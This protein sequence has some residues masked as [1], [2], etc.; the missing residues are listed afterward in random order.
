MCIQ[1][2][3]GK[4]IAWPANT[5]TLQMEQQSAEQQNIHSASFFF[6]SYEYPL[7]NFA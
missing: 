3:E 5:V 2:A 4:M 7:S 6:W 1:Q